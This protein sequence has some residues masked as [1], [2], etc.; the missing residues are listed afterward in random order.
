MKVGCTWFHGHILGG[1]TN[2]KKKPT[3]I[4]EA[5]DANEGVTMFIILSALLL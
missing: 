1:G 3:I 2:I 4:I 5:H